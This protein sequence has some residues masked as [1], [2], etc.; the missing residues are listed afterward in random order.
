MIGSYHRA[1]AWSRPIMLR[2]FFYAVILAGVTGALYPLAMYLVP[3][4][5]NLGDDARDL[6][7]LVVLMLSATGFFV[8]FVASRLNRR[9]RETMAVTDECSRRFD[10]SARAR[11][12][13]LNA[14]AFAPLR[15]TAATDADLN[16]VAK[17]I[18]FPARRGHLP[19]PAIAHLQG[20]V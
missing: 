14:Y 17:V 8:E 15:C 20:S 19:R 13:R 1:N 7:V 5:W 4:H 2:D 12:L 9:L 10:E 18:S 11:A 3:L 6:L 16:K